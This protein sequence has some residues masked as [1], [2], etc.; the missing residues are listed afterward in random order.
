M[1]NAIQTAL[2]GMAMGMAEVIPGVSGGT[3]AFITGIYEKLLNSIKAVG[4]EA[5]AAFRQNGAAGAWQAINGTFL[6]TLLIGMAGGIVVGV[7]GITYL[8]ETYPPAVWAFFFGLIVASAIY[9]GRQIESWGVKEVLALVAGT[10][11]AYWITIIAPAEGST[12]LAFVFV[13]GVLAISALILPGISGSF[14]LLLLGMYSY[15]I[16]DTLK[17]ALKTFASD[18]LLVLA[19]FTLGC[20]TGLMTVSR[21]LSWTFKH[22]RDLTLAILTGFMLGSLNKIWPWRN[23]V[24]WLRDAT[25]QIIMDDDGITPKKILLE[26][27][28]LPVGYEGEPLVMAVILAAIAGFAVVFILE[29]LGGQK[30]A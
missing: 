26:Q 29:R 7:F 11:F 24:E 25:G 23:P 3:I 12:S 10:L 18:K 21:L 27:N 30:D 14:I 19:V 13:C 6:L 4:P 8:L 20:L 22:Y 2:K 16:S 15:I 28:V 1:T 5:I 9:V 17:P